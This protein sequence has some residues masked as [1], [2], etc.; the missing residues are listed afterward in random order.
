MNLF[1]HS[2]PRTLGDRVVD[3]E[4][5]VHRR[6]DELRRAG[7]FYARLVPPAA[8]ASAARS[9]N[10]QKRAAFDDAFARVQPLLRRAARGR[11]YNMKALA[12]ENPF[13]RLLAHAPGSEGNWAEAYFRGRRSAPDLDVQASGFAEEREFWWWLMLLGAQPVVIVPALG[14]ELARVF[15]HT[16][17][18]DVLRTT[19]SGAL[20]GFVREGVSESGRAALI[21][22]F[23]GDEVSLLVFANEREILPLFE[24]ALDHARLS[25]Q[26]LRLLALPQVLPFDTIGAQV[27]ND[28]RRPRAGL[29]VLEEA[30][31]PIEEGDLTRNRVLVALVAAELIAALAGRPAA[32]MTEHPH[33]QPPDVRDKVL[34]WAASVGAT[35]S[36][37]DVERL[38]ARARS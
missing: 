1:I 11:V 29:E 22:K 8:P 25:D 35:T 4:E 31:T 38:R 24:L 21:P 33:F 19:L 15:A 27:W 3:F 26:S 17:H 13:R 5:F 7:F 30:L 37:A 6:A 9:F 18:V 23:S 28:V 36:P 16:S 32:V 20:R 10:E 14:D 34:K 2:M 12:Q